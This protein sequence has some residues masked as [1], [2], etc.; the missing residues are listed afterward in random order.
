MGVDTGTVPDAGEVNGLIVDTGD[1]TGETP[2]DGAVTWP[3]K[4]DCEVGVLEG[5]FDG[6]VV[7]DNVGTKVGILVGFNV[8]P[9]DTE[10]VGVNDG[11]IVGN[12]V[13]E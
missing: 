5:I 13:G 4:L 11:D 6:T 2:K 9:V 3:S 7:G 12:I 1:D 8:G 10:I